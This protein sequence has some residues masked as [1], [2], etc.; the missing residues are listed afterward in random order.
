MTPYS[1]IALD[2]V[3]NLYGTTYGG[4]SL[5]LGTVFKIRIDGTGFSVL[6]FLGATSSEGTQ[7]M[8]G[9]ILDGAGRLFGTTYT[10]GAFKYGTIFSMKVDGSA[11]AALH[12]FS[13]LSGDGEMPNTPLVLYPDGNLYG[14]TF[15]GGTSG[16]GTVFRVSTSGDAFRSLHSFAGGPLE[17]ANPFLCSLIA[18][19]SGTLYGTTWEGGSSGFG[20]VFRMGLDGASFAVLFSFQQAWGIQPVS[21]LSADESG[22]LYGTTARGGPSDLGTVFR[23][24]QD[25][26]GFSTLHVFS[27]SV[28]EGAFPDGSVI[29]DGSTNLFGVTSSG[30]EFGYGSIFGLHSNGA[31]FSLLHSFNYSVDGA[32]PLGALTLVNT[33]TLVGI[34]QSGPLGGAVFSIKMDGSAFSVIHSFSGSDGSSPNSAIVPGGSGALFGTT[35]SGGVASGGTV[36]KIGVDGNGFAVLHSFA[37][38]AGDGVSPLA[39]A[40][41]H[42]LG[43]LYG[44]TSGGGTSGLGV[45]FRMKADGTEYSVIHSFSGG[46]ADGDR[47]EGSVAIDPSGNLYGATLFGG[48]Y[49]LGVIYRLKTNGNGFTLLHS[50]AGGPSDGETPE[51]SLIL[52]VNDN[53]YGTTGSGGTG[54]GGVIFKLSE[55]NG[56]GASLSAPIITSPMQGQALGSS[57]VVFSWGIVNGAADYQFLV[58]DDSD[59]STIYSGSNTDGSTTATI[60]LPNGGLTFGVRACSGGFADANCGPFATVDFTVNVLPPTTSTTKFYTLTPCRV[61]DTRNAAGPYGGP[62]LQAGIS[63]VFKLTGQCG[64]PTGSKAASVNITVVTPTDPGELKLNPTGADPQIASA[65]SFPA[66]RV[67]AN[68]AMVF[69]GTDGAMSVFD[70]QDTGTTHF[71]IDVN[72]YFK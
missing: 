48:A 35:E 18:D 37:S 64:I 68:N 22:S 15:S 52:D 62:A 25:G 14:T 67:L 5:G 56:G 33:G 57:R 69:L 49:G 72:G 38:G 44:T 60:D 20:T 21:P 54:G 29:T 59:G 61:A 50:F 27:D 12:D 4:G 23:V 41:D 31:G 30:G 70:A 36:Y 11:F 53:L 51:G 26:N 40:V 3:G 71:I 46:P 17:G 6:R 47:P 16:F 58:V 45:V 63:R 32:T 13:G 1:P 24:G 65:I 7:P 66:G 28:S 9:V 2:G 39:V 55:A 42:N 19:S 34:T 8:A 43:Y 10:G